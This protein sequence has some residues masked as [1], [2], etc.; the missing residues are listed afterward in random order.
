MNL[1]NL[2]NCMI[3]SSVIIISSCSKDSPTPDPILDC[4]SVE[5]GIA[6]FDDCGTCHESYMYVG[7][8]VLL[9]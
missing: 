5:N 1:K 2:L 7:M 4:N 9:L 3:L 6:V 8:G